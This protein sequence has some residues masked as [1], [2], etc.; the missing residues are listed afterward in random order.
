[1]AGRIHEEDIA[2]VRERS[3]IEDVVGDYVALRNAGGGALKGLCPFHDEKTPSFQ[4]TPARGLYYCFGCQVGGDVIDFLQR[5]Q[6][7]SFVEAVQVLADRAA[8]T[9]RIE[10]DGTTRQPG[11]RKQILEA[12][13]A[14]REFFA[15]Q[16]DSP[17]AIEGRRFLAGRDFDRDIALRFSIG[18][19]PRHGRALT[20]T[21]RGKGFSEEVLKAAGLSRDGGRD[22]F[23]GRVLWPIRDSAQATLG[24]GARRIYDDD[25]MPAKYLNT[26]ESPVYKKSQVLYGLDLARREIGRR[27]QAVIVEGYTDVMAAHLAGVETAVA[28]CGTAFG[29]DHARLLQ[30]LMGRT[31]GL[32]GEVIFTFDGD[33]AGQAAALKVFKGDQNFI[34]QTYVAI[35]PTGL[36]PCDLRMQ[37][38]EA[39]LRELV[40]RRVPLYRFVMSNIAKGYDLDRAEGRLAAAREAVALLGSI[41][42][43]SLVDQYMRELAGVL[44]MDIEEVRR[45]GASVRRQ[46]ANAPHHEPLDG[47]EPPEGD[48][49]GM[50]NPAD[51]ALLAER[52][53]LKLMLQHPLLFDAAWNSATSDDFTHPG[54]VAVFGLIAANPF[55]EDWTERL[56]AAAQ[57]E[58]LQQLLLALLVEPLVMEA[59]ESYALKHTSQLRL[60]RVRRELRDLK[61]RIQRTDPIEEAASHRAQFVQLTELERQRRELLAILHD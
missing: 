61:S 35:E 50:P 33:K 11:L 26:P 30:R 13:D 15:A 20:Q 8:I 31:D 45:E 32:H 1:M 16:L 23:V 2:S 17:E 40:A 3:R 42:D 56:R 12:N 39:A 59:D 43:K 47:P 55:G 38:G 53:T 49:A 60:D 19:A 54:Y 48:A 52:D 5:Q 7:L 14:A 18:Y 57:S 22:F 34:S 9:L 28:S 27:S 51:P 10:D 29:D 21:L 58:Q 41:R 6:N 4:V 37:H 44:G 36:D 24:F 25:R 46:A